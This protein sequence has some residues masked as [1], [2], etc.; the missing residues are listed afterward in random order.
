MAFK[1]L[2]S[3]TL[4]LSATVLASSGGY[5]L[6]SSRLSPAAQSLFDY[7]MQVQDSRYDAYYSFIWYQDKGPWSTRFTAWY[8]PG[9]LYRAQ[10][11]DIDNAISSIEAVLSTQMT[12]D[13]DSAWYGTYRLSPDAPY[14]TANGDLY[15]PKIYTTYDPNWR[16]FVGTALVQVVEEFSHLLTDDL[17]S[18]IETSLAENAVGA[19]RRNGS[20]PEDDNLV[21]GYS[22][23]GLMRAL[24]VGWI[25]KRL[26]NQTFIDFARKQGNELLELF[27]RD[28]QNVLSEYNAPNYY[29]MDMWALAANVAYGPKDAPM[30]NNSKHIITEVWKDVA[31]HFNPYL[32]NMVG[33]YD[34]A[35]TRDATEHSAIISLFWWGVFGRECGPQP[36]LGEADLLYDVAQGASVSL[37]MDTVSQYIDK[38]TA[39]ALKAK[40]WWEGSRFI[41]KTIYEDLETQQYRTASSWVSAG[42]MIGGQTVAETVN[43]GDQFVPAIVHWAS[44]PNHA[45]YPYNGFFSLY[46]SASTITSEVG[47]GTL[48]VSYPNTTQEGTNIFTFALAGIPPQYFRSP[49]FKITGLEN[50]PCLSVNISAPG[51]EALQITYGTQLRDH[52]IYNISYAVPTDFEGIPSVSFELEYTCA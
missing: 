6:S 23:P 24:T 25:G 52:Y 20:Y 40:G 39:A 30:T 31:T 16:E 27:E 11:N 45:P 33:P 17:I 12:E 51:L 22:N 29:G 15:P 5:N 28:G 14:P 18:R 7:S 4:A 34:R 10:G 50:L 2:I 41:S 46:P 35:Y 26:N 8:I 47:D 44:D 19:M 37:I 36:P 32:G 3:V 48:R 13:Y 38:D 1:N 42:L 21:L 43:R 9:L 49:D